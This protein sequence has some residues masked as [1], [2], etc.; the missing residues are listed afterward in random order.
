MTV[1]LVGAGPGDP[2]LITV[3][4]ADL[5]RRADVIV[6]DRLAADSLLD[7]A[8]P[9]CELIDAGKGPG[10]VT[11]SQ[12]ET[13]QVLIEHGRRGVLVVRLKGGDPFVFGR[14]GEEAQALRQARIEYEIVPGISSA[15]AVPAYAGVP[16]THRDLAAQVTIVTAHERPGKPRADVD[17]AALAGLPGT[18]AVLMGV[19]RLG[20]V[21]SALIA[22]GKPPG[23]PVCVTQS[24][25][26]AAQRSVV[27]TLAT[28]AGDVEAAG[29]RSPAVTVIGA[30]AGLR[31]QL[32]WA[33]RRPL[34]GRRIVVTRAR[35]QASGLVE[36]LR[37]LGA[38]VDECA[39][40]RIEPLKGDAIDARAYGLVCVTSPNAPRL[41]LER[42]GGDA[43]ALAGVT[44][45]AIGP[46]TAAALREVG[47]IADVV[48]ERFVAEGLLEALPG[49]LGGV[50]A[51]VARA[52]EARDTLPQGLRAAGAEVDVVPL[53]RTVAA[54]P[55]HPERM[56]TADAVAFTASSTVTRFAEA[57]A[58]RD[59]SRVRG[60][61]IGPVTSA[62]ARELGVGVIAEA[63]EHDLDGLVRALL[64]VLS[65]P[66]QA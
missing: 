49:D 56:L 34:H 3:R 50:R 53:Y 38:E 26:T 14:G 27:G 21:A 46:G 65:Q 33:E 25:T 36:R 57:L 8:R 29:I 52:E 19:A 58:G 66:P 45:A 42:C 30:V 20:P 32:A 44:V 60:V 41:L 31:E 16:V 37:D 24:G 13:T 22:A 59:L 47:L 11:L 40:I 48:A 61:S 35:A 39:V 2:R 54:A 18:L 5:L 51:L 28:I 7:L 10:D 62:T 4:G 6:Y 15:I 63:A 17:W 55:R 9:E 1:Y 23:T 43:R 64:Q 12:D